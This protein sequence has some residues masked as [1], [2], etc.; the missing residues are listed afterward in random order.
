MHLRI[1]SDPDFIAGKLDTAFM[2]SLPSPARPRQAGVSPKPSDT[3]LTAELAEI[4]ETLLC[5]L[6][7]LPVIAVVLVAQMIRWNIQ[8]ET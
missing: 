6:G 3:T 5:D 1:L 7:L 8:T 2:G 4:A